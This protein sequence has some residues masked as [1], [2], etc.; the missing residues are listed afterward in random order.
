M[1]RENFAVV[2]DLSKRNMQLLLS[3]NLCCLD[4][5]HDVFQNY[6]SVLC[7]SWQNVL[8]P[9]SKNLSCLCSDHEVYN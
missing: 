2:L 4:F 6:S 3:V 7:S 5:N 9:I 8:L 1:N